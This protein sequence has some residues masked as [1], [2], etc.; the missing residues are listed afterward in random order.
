MRTF[1]LERSRVTSTLNANERSY[2]T[3]YQLVC[4]KTDE[5]LAAADPADNSDPHGLVVPKLCLLVAVARHLH[6]PRVVFQPCIGSCAGF[7]VTERFW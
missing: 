5:Q 6:L 1:L 2:H 4:G 3:M 7:A